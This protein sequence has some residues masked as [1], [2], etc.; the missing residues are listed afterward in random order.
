MSEPS[1][2]D[3]VG[4]KKQP[5]K[6]QFK[7][8][9]SGNPG[10]RPAQPKLDMGKSLNKE[11]NDIVVTGLG[12]KLTGFEGF[13]QSVVDRLLQGDSKAIPEFMRLGTEAKLFKIVADPT[14]LSGVYVCKEYF[15]DRALGTEG[16]WYS[17]GDG[18]GFWVDP[19]TKE[20][21]AE[22]PPNEER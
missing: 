15:R 22:R 6:G 17:L 3:A 16:G 19:I 18:L 21:S 20:K 7:P 9:V 12:K 5:R 10:G 11:L 2:T 13:V 4:S 8:G 1:E 14:R